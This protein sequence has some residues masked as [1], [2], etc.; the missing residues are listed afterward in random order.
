[1]KRSQ[2]TLAPW[3]SWSTSF[4]TSEIRHSIERMR[5][6]PDVERLIALPDV[7]LAGNTCNGAVVATRERIYPAAVGADIGCGMTALPLRTSIAFQEDLAKLHAILKDWQRGVAILKS[8]S[9]DFEA[10]PSL[11][12]LSAQSLQV[13]AERDGRYQLGTLGRGN[14][15]LELQIDTQDNLWLLVHSGSRVMGQIVTAFHEAKAEISKGAPAYFIAESELG[16]AYQTDLTWCR[17]YASANRQAI[18][19]RALELL[20]DIAPCDADFT[21][22]RETDHNHLET[23][24]GLLIHRKGAQGI[25]KG[26][27][28]VIP[29]SMATATYHVEGRGSPEALDSCSH[30]AG[31][32]LSRTNAIQKLT[33]REV[34]RSLAG[35]MHDDSQLTRIF[36]EAPGAYRD[37]EAVMRAQRELVRRTNE[38]HPLLTLKGGR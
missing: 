23:R 31:R 13:A 33:T 36:D 32:Q 24:A 26:G 2:A 9:V 6:W 17:R 18:L 28:G 1:M 5:A 3:H 4:L 35:V 8:S 16:H 37:I 10:I 11:N 25:A 14:H 38:L 30:G 20:A 34:R 19:R 29:G 12:A 27:W 22:S 21:A 15:F 7:H